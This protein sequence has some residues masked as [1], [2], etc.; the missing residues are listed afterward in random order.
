MSPIPTHARS[1]D[2]GRAG[3]LT[4]LAGVAVVAASVLGLAYA[5]SV[6]P[7][8]QAPPA[9]ERSA[10][11]SRTSYCSGDLDGTRVVAGAE[12]GRVRVGGRAAGRDARAVPRAGTVV[13]AD[14]TAAPVSYAT[15][16]A[17]TPHGFAAQPCPDPRAEWWFD[18]AGS[19]LRHHSRLTLSNPLPGSSVVDVEVLGPSGPVRAPGLRGLTLQ[20]GSSRSLDL[21]KVAATRGDL[22]VHVSTSR[23]LVSASMSEQYAADYLSKQTTAYVPGQP[24]AARSALLGGLPAEPDQAGL[25]ITNPDATEAVVRLRLVS[26]RG[27]FVPTRHAQVRVPPQTVLTVPIGDV[28]GRG[29]GALRLTS[30]VPVSATVRAVSGR[31]E[32]LVGAEAALGRVA[33]AGVPAGSTATLQLVS[34]SA[35]T[36]RVE[37]VATTARGERRTHRVRVPAR[38]LAGLDLPSG[39]RAVTVRDAGAVTGSLLVDGGGGRVATVPLRSVLTETRVPTALP[40]W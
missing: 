26:S 30:Q 37:V 22:A 3:L 39:T 8:R 21:A 2:T 31:T 36:S 13:R 23:G 29:A 28:L 40:A 12:R 4:L 27:S 25:V 7:P 14:V 38:G 33:A 15:Q 32:S 6:T 16:Y 24:E 20:S 35:R 11:L 9:A 18:G 17:D 34:T 5:A 10:R 19:S 1:D